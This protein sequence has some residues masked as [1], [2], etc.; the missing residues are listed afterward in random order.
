MSVPASAHVG[1]TIIIS[2]KAIL[3][4]GGD[5]NSFGER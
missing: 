4:S 3:V 1:E 5:Q 2:L